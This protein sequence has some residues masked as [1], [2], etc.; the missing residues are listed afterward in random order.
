MTLNDRV[1][2]LAQSLA[3]AKSAAN[4]G[5]EDVDF[6]SNL[7]E[8]LDVANVQMEVARAVEVHQDMSQE[9]KAT[10]LGQLNQE[11]LG[12]DEVSAARLDST[13]YSFQTSAGR[14][15]VRYIC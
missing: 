9:D 10:A 5:A 8:R 13:F 11:L 1:Y 4:L 14:T 2:Y 7:Q 12:L 3:S 6:T 15:G